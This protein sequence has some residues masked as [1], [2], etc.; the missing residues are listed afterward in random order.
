VSTATNVH[1]LRHGYTLADLD[2]LA[3]V[4]ITRDRS[5]GWSAAGDYDGRFETAWDAIA[6]HLCATQDAPEPHDLIR[7]ALHALRSDSKAHLRHHGVHNNER[8]FGIFWSEIAGATPSCERKVVERTTLT[9]IWPQLT[10]YQ[11]RALLALAAL[12]DYQ[13]AAD[14][15]G[16]DY[17]TFAAKVSKARRAFLALWHEGEQPSRPWG[18][19]RRPTDHL[20]E[21]RYQAN[22]ERRRA[23]A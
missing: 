8:S 11:Q 5:A 12:G 3:R 21:R 18:N 2:R 10:P 15:L 7:A 16:E 4:A 19:D 22:T 1:E 23:A 9:Q 17:R 13:A 6:H 14:A 20:R